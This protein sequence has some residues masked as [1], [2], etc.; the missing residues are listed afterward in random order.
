M[1]H[2]DRNQSTSAVCVPVPDANRLVI[3]CEEKLTQG[4]GDIAA[5]PEENCSI[6][7]GINHRIL[8]RMGQHVDAGIK[9]EI[10]DVADVATIGSSDII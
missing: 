2:S 1:L 7:H 4:P 10:L 9:Y 3:L 6:V 8:V 5:H